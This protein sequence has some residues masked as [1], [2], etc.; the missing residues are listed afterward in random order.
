MSNVFGRQIVLMNKAAEFCATPYPAAVHLA[1]NGTVL[2]NFNSFCALIFL[3][4][5][6]STVGPVA[7]P[8]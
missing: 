5:I 4:Y 7:Q 3:Q 8:V 1:Y 2:S 6:S